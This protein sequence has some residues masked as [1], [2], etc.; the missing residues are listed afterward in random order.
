M[1]KYYDRYSDFRY[2]GKINLIPGITLDELNSDK[3]IIYKL[4]DTRL[5]KISNLY[6]NTPYCGWLI[7]LAN[8]QFGGLEFNIPDQTV[9][10]I[11]FPFESAINRYT[12]QINKYKSL[13]VGQ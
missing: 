4:G 5:D 10:R 1:V 13:Y 2:D 8:P 12:A 7:M 11:P 3:R 6:Y 9:I